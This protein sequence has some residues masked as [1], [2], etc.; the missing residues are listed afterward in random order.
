MSEL[1]KK[2]DHVCIVVSDLEKSIN[3]YAKYFDFKLLDQKK[4]SGQWIED[5][6]GLVYVKAEYAM[7]GHSALKIE[8]LCFDTPT[9]EKIA[10]NKIP[11]T[12]GLRHLALETDNIEEVYNR[13]KKEDILGAGEIITNPFGKKMFYLFGPDE[14]II[15]ICQYLK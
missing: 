4:L 6:T 1:I 15:E 9:G 12:M 3:F 13:L 14:E 2:L 10:Q 5:V 11:N 8:L 7:L